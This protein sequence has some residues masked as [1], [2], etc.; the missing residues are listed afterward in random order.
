[1]SFI[2]VFGN[3]R[4]NLHELLG[5]TLNVFWEFHTCIQ[6]IEGR[7]L[8]Y[9]TTQ[10][11]VFFY[12]TLDKSTLGLYEKNKIRIKTKIKNLPPPNKKK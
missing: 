11:V 1:M 8:L 4:N 3:L 6:K 7:N 2:Y 12:L 9:F 10:D 5:F